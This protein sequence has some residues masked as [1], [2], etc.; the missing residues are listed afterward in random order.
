METHRLQKAWCQRSERSAC[1]RPLPLQ[2]SVPPSSPS[3][4]PPTL[5]LPRSPPTARCCLWWTRS[6]TCTALVSACVKEN[7]RVQRGGRALLQVVDASLGTCAAL[8]AGRGWAVYCFV[9][10]LFKDPRDTCLQISGCSPCAPLPCSPHLPPR[11]L[12][13]PDLHQPGLPVLNHGAAV[14]PSVGPPG[15][16]VRGPWHA[17]RLERAL[18]WR[19]RGARSFCPVQ[20]GRLA[21]S[22][23]YQTVAFARRSVV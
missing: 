2:A 16:E 21:L 15:A 12:R 7:E 18:G 23:G 3:T 20:P 6:G 22:W 19:A 14:P 8:Q 4:A 11:R 5:W 17:R 10:L 13:N 1:V 9:R